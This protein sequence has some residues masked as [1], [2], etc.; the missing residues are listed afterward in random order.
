MDDDGENGEERS[1]G[2]D[3]CSEIGG[4]AL[5][6][7]GK[8][9]TRYVDVLLEPALADA[10]VEDAA[11]LIEGIVATEMGPEILPVQ[12]EDEMMKIEDDSD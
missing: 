8:A 11:R 7:I 6:K 10:R 1:I 12:M 3:H 9:L 5:S 2:F 4:M